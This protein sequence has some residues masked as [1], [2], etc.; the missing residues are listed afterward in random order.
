M[1]SWLPS[2]RLKIVVEP[3]SF[4]LAYAA[5]PPII[6]SAVTRASQLQS[7]ARCVCSVPESLS[8]SSSELE[9][10]EEESLSLE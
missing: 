2:P 7:R 6:L 3:M 5:V 9:E 1:T 8:L 10:G 4:L